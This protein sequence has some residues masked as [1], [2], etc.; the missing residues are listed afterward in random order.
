MTP[1]EAYNSPSEKVPIDMAIGRIADRE[2][3]IFPPC[4]PV[5]FP[6]EEIKKEHIEKIKNAIDLNLAVTGIE[7]MVI[8]VIKHEI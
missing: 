5:F 2:V 4:I 3:T 1:K 8:S 7:N 6:G